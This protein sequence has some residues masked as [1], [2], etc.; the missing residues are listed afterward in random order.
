[1]SEPRGLGTA[2]LSSQAD[3]NLSQ[4]H[5]SLAFFNVAGGEKGALPFGS[6][7]VLEVADLE[8]RPAPRGCRF[9]VPKLLP[10]SPRPSLSLLPPPNR[11][12]PT[13]PLIANRQFEPTPADVCTSRSGVRRSLT[14]IPDWT[15]VQA[16][17]TGVRLSKFVCASRN[18][19]GA[20]LPFYD[21]VISSPA[22]DE[23]TRYTKARTRVQRPRTCVRRPPYLYLQLARRFLPTSARVCA[24][25]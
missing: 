25:V 24:R 17:S 18:I 11:Q 23:L 6:P 13:P 20:I 5:F 14:Y 1:L 22:L 15:H 7:S 9:N 3:L 19:P 12:P 8:P 21:N 10:R 4:R 16:A 2:S